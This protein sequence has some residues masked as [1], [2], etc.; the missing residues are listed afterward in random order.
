[1][2][3]NEVGVFFHGFTHIFED[4]SALF[5]FFFEFVVDDGR[6]VLSAHSCEVF[7][8]AFGDLEFV[9][10]ISDVGRD[11]ISGGRDS[12]GCNPLLGRVSRSSMQRRFRVVD[13]I[14]VV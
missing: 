6:I 7:F 11:G 5:S 8:F 13:D 3:A 10:D 1:M 2:G 4:D 14:F 9:E 12:R